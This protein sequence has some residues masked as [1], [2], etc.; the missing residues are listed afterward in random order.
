MPEVSVIIPTYNV[1]KYVNEAVD[2][3]FRQTFQ[4]FEIIIVDDGSTDATEQKLNEYNG[5]IIYMKQANQGP[6]AARNRGIERASG[7]FIAFL[8]AD[9]YWLPTKLNKQVEFARSHPE[10]GIVTTDIIWFDNERI[11][12]RSLKDIY[13]VKSGRVL[14]DLL[15][16][17]WIGTSAAMVRRECFNQGIRFDPKHKYGEDWMLWMQIAARWPIHFI[18]EVLVYHRLYP[19]SLSAGN[20]EAQFENLFNNLETLRRSIPT[21]G[22][23]LIRAA[24]YRISWR[25]G[26]AD[27]KRI[28]LPAARFKIHKALRYEPF[29]VK[30]WA[31]LLIAHF[32]ATSLRMARSSVRSLRRLIRRSLKSE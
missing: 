27:I 16:H 4:D 29:G 10:F 21:L 22:D 5:R 9:D 7:A 3:V 25:R 30:A 31:L 8:D 28:E 24:S 13:P 15:F 19:E 6:S 23:G 18:E 14:K 32:P 17:N 12:N 2:S 11:L 1:E 20:S 26:W